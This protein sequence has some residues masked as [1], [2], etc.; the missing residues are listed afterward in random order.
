[1]R[2][3]QNVASDAAVADWYARQSKRLREAR[4][5]RRSRWTKGLAR[6]H[7]LALMGLRESEQEAMK[8]RLGEHAGDKASTRG[9][10][11]S[12]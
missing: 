5:A 11:K 7:Q 2:S 10:A 3:K 9:C 8:R 4:A 12:G 1:M 6:A